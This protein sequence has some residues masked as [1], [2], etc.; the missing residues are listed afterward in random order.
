LNEQLPLPRRVA[1]VHVLRCVRRS[2]ALLAMRR[3]HLRREHLGLRLRFPNG[4]SARVYRET[5]VDH[6]RAEEP[7]LLIVEFRLRHVRGRGHSLFRW[8]SLLNTVLFLGFPGLV[9]KLWMAND[10][11]GVYRGLYEWDGPAQAEH[12]ARCLWRV[13]ALVSE[14]ESIHYLVIPNRSRHDLL[15]ELAELAGP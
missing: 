5:V 13:L 1:L 3:T 7:C 4:A 12:Y 10:E 8:E 9:S 14:R 15:A 6:D 2:V 11:N